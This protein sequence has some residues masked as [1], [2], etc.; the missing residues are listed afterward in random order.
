MINRDEYVQKLK[1]QLDQWNAEV[2]KWEAQAKTAQAGMQAE[3]QKQLALYRSR[4][5]EA[6]SQLRKVQSAS[7][8]A[9]SDMMRGTDDAWKKMQE[10]FNQARSRFDK[11]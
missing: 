11:K 10:A 5:D 3:Y 6:V 7:A 1:S 8:D 4:R 9:W 2:A